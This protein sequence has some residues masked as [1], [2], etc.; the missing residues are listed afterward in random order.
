MFSFGSENNERQTTEQRLTYEPVIKTEQWEKVKAI[1][2][3]VL[4]E[5]LALLFDPDSRIKPLCKNA[6]LSFTFIIAA[7]F[8]LL[9]SL[10]TPKLPPIN[11]ALFFNK[12][13]VALFFG[14]IFY[15][16]ATALCIY[17]CV[18]LLVGSEISYVEGL[19]I[20]SI[21]FIPLIIA[22]ILG[23]IFSLI[24]PFF[25]HYFEAVGYL[26]SILLMFTALQIYLE[27]T[28]RAVIYL[29][30]IIFT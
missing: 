26:I 13:A 10:L 8:I 23:A 30:P 3:K 9:G 12:G 29:T 2:I 19:N 5:A 4:N 18:R 17:L 27:L 11:L 25:V 28:A 24:S 16:F 22:F 7:V 14:N 6:D 15:Y 1:F 21:S 20:V